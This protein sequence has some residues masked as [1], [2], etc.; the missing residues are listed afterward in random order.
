M[1]HHMVQIWFMFNGAACK[2][3]QGK[4]VLATTSSW[5]TEEEVKGNK[6]DFNKTIEGNPGK[7]K[8][9]LIE[10]CLL[11]KSWNDELT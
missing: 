11:C 5:I 3:A 1:W 9:S 2:A 10:Y 4:V 8:N 7:S 6:S